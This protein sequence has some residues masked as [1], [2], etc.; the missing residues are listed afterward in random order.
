MASSGGVVT[1]KSLDLVSFL[2]LGPATEEAA[3][4]KAV[5]GVILI[6]S[7]GLAVD[8]TVTLT[9][10]LS[11][12]TTKTL[13]LYYPSTK[14]LDFEIVRPY[15]RSLEAFSC[16]RSQVFC[17]SPSS[18]LTFFILSILTYLRPLVLNLSFY[19][20]YL[21]ISLLRR[22]IKSIKSLFFLKRAKIL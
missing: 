6:R 21:R 5:V 8:S 17:L 11:P 2:W 12:K 16:L 7:S 1:T 19:A 22:R 14:R 13:L 18:G 4:G 9:S 3:V 15:S 20:I 10:F